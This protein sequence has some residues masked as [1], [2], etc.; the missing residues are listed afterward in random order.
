MLYEMLTGRTPFVADNY[1]AL[2]HS[3]IYEPVPPP[4]RINPRISPAV[5][6]VVLKALEKNPADRF[7]KA[8]EMAVALDQ[9][10]AAQTPVAAMT[11]RAAAQPAPASPPPAPAYSTVVC[12]RCHQPN[13][14]QQGFCSFCGQP[15]VP[16]Q[17]PPPGPYQQYP[18]ATGSW[19]SCPYC[20]AMNEPLNRFSTQCATGL[21]VGFAPL[22]CR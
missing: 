9:A 8:T 19:T 18:Q 22:L 10:V 17:S 21:F 13:A 16:G 6:S 7:Q 5:Q 4:S 1:T 14:A 12:P 20:L 15:L 2:A 3:H 11:G